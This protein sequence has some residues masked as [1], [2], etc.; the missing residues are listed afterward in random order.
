MTGT[1]T[2]RRHA[3]V[4]GAGIGGLTAAAALAQRGWSVEVHERAPVI[5]A[6]GSG[7]YIGENG[8]RV[9]EAV[10]AYAETVDGGIRFYRRETR[11]HRNRTVGRYHWPPESGLRIHVVAR[12]KLVLALRNQAEAAGARIFTGSEVQAATPDGV[13][14]LAD[15]SE[16]R[17]DLV[18]GADGVYSKVRTSVGFPGQIKSLNCGAIRAIVPRLPTDRDL[19]DDTYAEFWSGVRRVFYAPISPQET[20]LALMTVDNDVKGT[21]EPPDLDAWSE[22]FPHIAPVLRRIVNPLRWTPFEQVK[23]KQWHIGRVALLGDAAHAMS[24]NLGQ[25]G[26]TAMMDGISL[27][28]NVSQTDD[29]EAG[30]TRWEQRERPIV[31]RIQFVSNLYGKLSYWPT[32]PRYLALWAMNRS[33]WVKN[34]RTVASNYVP[35][36]VEAP[37][38]GARAS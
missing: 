34:I 5:R 25:G 1:S 12:E 27:A 3:V 32:L 28:A 18:I 30:L 14:R 10:G 17:G 37:A 33:E 20:Y 8:L 38:T 31:E 21:R 13:V 11:D 7:I 26:G 23:L 15:G 6:T 19:P 22:A 29:L 4:A 35:D 24:A 9:L 36:G 16:R 2:R